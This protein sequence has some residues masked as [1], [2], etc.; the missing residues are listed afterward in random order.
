MS[1]WPRTH[2]WQSREDI[3][4]SGDRVDCI[5]NKVN[6]IGV[7]VNRVSD[8]VDCNKLSN[9]SCCRFVAQTGD[10][11][12][13]IGN[14]AHRIGDSRLCCQFVVGFGNSHLCR[15]CV[16]GF[17]A[18][19]V[20]DDHIVMMLCAPVAD[21]FS[22]PLAMSIHSNVPTQPVLCSPFTNSFYYRYT[23]AFCH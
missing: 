5:G 9:S 12:N 1:L 10:K 2:W 19:L 20:S 18:T 21:D 14:K 13:C 6:R 22:I 15:Q 7:K 16:P 11:V 4:H 23:S 3:R 17:K 8:R